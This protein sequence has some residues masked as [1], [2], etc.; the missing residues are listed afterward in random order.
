MKKDV[1]AHTT[2]QNGV[3]CV[4]AFLQKNKWSILAAG[5]LIQ[6]LTG[7]PAAWGVFQKAVCQGYSLGEEDGAM[8]FSFVICFFG[9]GCILG[10]LLQDKA[11]PRAAALAGAGLLGGGFALGGLVVPE[12]SPWLFYLLFSVPVGLGCSFLYPAVMSCAQKWYAD[13]KGLATGVIGGAVGL[14]GA[15]LTA[16]GRLTIGWWGIR[17]SLLA[18]GILMAAVCGLASILLE[19]P[20]GKAAGAQQKQEKQTRDYTIK[21]MVKTPQYWLL[22]AVVCLGTPAVLLF[23]PIIVEM[24]QERGLPEAAGLACIWIGS[25]F[26]AGGRLAMPWLSDKI[27]RRYTDLILFAAMAGLSV[28]FAFVGGWWVIAVYSFLTFCYSGA[29]A[30]LPAATT[31]LFGLKSSGVNYGFVALGMSAGSVGFPLLARVLGL[32]TARHWIAVAAAALGFVLLWF[33]KPPQGERL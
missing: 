2:L 3:V 18:L 17:G 23:S 8:I 11:G 20:Q 9:I 10:G 31:D 25:I 28:A 30:V 5:A 19:D 13:N 27:G 22:T 26:S 15:A 29:A 6:I 33:L 21:E 12:G 14:S 24:A 7:I 1:R 4:Q 32:T 16:L